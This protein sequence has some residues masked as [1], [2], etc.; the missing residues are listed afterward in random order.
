MSP[1]LVRGVRGQADLNGNGAVAIDELRHY[2][3]RYMARHQNRRKPEHPVVR[4]TPAS[5]RARLV[6]AQVR[7]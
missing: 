4:R 5:A 6:R 3:V 1:A 7:R 2:V